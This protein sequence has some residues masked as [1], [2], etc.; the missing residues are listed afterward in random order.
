MGE[1]YALRRALT[2]ST[3]RETSLLD[4]DMKS[5]PTKSLRAGA[6]RQGGGG[7]R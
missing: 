3:S 5:Q 7:T 1:N 4:T 2:D 6:T